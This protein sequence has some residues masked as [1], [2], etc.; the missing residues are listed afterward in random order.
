MRHSDT[1]EFRTSSFLAIKQTDDIDK[2]PSIDFAV[3]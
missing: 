2:T 3:I 1:G